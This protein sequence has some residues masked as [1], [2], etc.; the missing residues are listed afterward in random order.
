MAV[1]KPKSQMERPKKK[2][3]LGNF[4]INI[5]IVMKIKKQNKTQHPPNDSVFLSAGSK[6]LQQVHL[7]LEL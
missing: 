6:N 4:L 2:I 5:K 1:K 7:D 3:G